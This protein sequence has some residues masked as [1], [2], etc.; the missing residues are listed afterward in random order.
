MSKKNTFK[1]QN[2]VRMYVCIKTSPTQET[3]HTLASLG[4]VV[5][6]HLY[7]FKS[8]QLPTQVYATSM[9]ESKSTQKWQTNHKERK[10]KQTESSV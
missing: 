9:I 6:Q 3:P 7:L 5:Y 10:L 2:F 8:K 4:N 1:E